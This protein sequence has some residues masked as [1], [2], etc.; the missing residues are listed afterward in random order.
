MHKARGKRS[1]KS[2]RIPPSV[3][4]YKR[5]NHSKGMQEEENR[6]IMMHKNITI[7]DL[8]EEGNGVA[9][10]EG[11][12]VFVTNALPGEVVD[13]EITSS[14][15]KYDQG[16]VV[17]FHKM[18]ES[19]QEPFCRHYFECGGCSL[20]HLDYEKGLE[21]K[22]LWVKNSFQKIAGVEVA[23]PKILGMKKNKHYR[24]K[25]VFHGFFRG[26]NYYLGFYKKGS[27]T[28]LRVTQCLLLPDLFLRIKESLEK[29]AVAA[30]CFPTEV[31]LRTNG[32]EVFVYLENS[33]QEN[34]EILS[35]ELK[36]AFPEIVHCSSP[37]REKSEQTLDM[38]LGSK[39]FL[40]SPTSFFQVNLEAAKLLYDQIGELLPL[41]HGELTLVDL[42]SGVGSIGLYLGEGFKSVVGFESQESAVRQA[43][44]N[45]RRNGL[46]EARYVQGTVE[47]LIQEASLD[48]ASLV[49]VDPPRSGVE[50]EVVEALLASTNRYLIY[51]GCGL[52]KMTRDLGKLV[53]GGYGLQAV[54]CV[55]MFPWT[56]HVE[57]VVKLERR[58]TQ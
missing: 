56:G 50:P 16:R 23:L 39:S 48:E 12:V 35:K 31:T 4:K 28:L 44:V 57:T 43:R 21:L 20:Q 6:R 7:T 42:Y 34:I 25:V 9:R 41:D 17:A 24:N 37:G 15:K 58:E 29:L 18:D 55:D 11:K 27:K 30:Q 33:N 3:V 14:K 1:S 26:D 51:V 52:G 38:P 47:S 36:L 54:S 22:S 2:L 46:P 32:Q 8:T 53:E 49:I 19:R 10:V 40:I 5:R 13:L 45:A